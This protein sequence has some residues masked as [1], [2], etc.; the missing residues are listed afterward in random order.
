LGDG[1]PAT[2]AAGTPSIRY[3]S[4]ATTLSPRVQASRP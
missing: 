4:H 2:S 3:R 1:V